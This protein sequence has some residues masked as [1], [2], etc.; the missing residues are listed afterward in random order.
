MWLSIFLGDY[1]IFVDL[2][3]SVRADMG[4]LSELLNQNQSNLYFSDVHAS[5]TVFGGPQADPAAESV[6]RRD[7]RQV[8]GELPGPEGGLAQGSRPQV[9]GRQEGVAGVLRGVQARRGLQG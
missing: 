9:G 1:V 6:R 8:Q 5:D 3:D 7:L 4:N 2:P